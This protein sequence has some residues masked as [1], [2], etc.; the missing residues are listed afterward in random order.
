MPTI[1]R[2]DG[3]L[4]RM[5]PGDHHP[6]HFH[7]WTAGNGEALILIGDLSVARGSL[8]KH[9]LELARAW[10]ADNMTFLNSEWDRL[11]GRQ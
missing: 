9:E 6:P 1:A 8:R 11:N 7:V 3:V 2:L 4:I 5:F 10:A